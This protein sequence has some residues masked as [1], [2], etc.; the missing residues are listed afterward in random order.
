MKTFVYKDLKFDGCSRWLM[1]ILL[2]CISLSGY[3]QAPVITSFS[4]ASAKPGDAVTLTGTDFNTT[5]TNNIVFFGATRGTVT[6]ATA[7]SVTVTVPTGATYAPITLLNS[8]TAL[9]CASRSPFHPVYTPA[10][11]GISSNDISSKVDFSTAAQPQQVNIGDMDGDGKPDLVFVNLNS[12]SV[13]VLRNTSSSGSMS[14]SASSFTTGVGPYDVAIGDLD[15]DGKLDLAVVNSSSQS[16]T[17]SMFRNTSSSGL[18]SFAAPINYGTGTVPTHLAIG[19]LDVDGKPDVAVLNIGSGTISVFRNQSTIGSFSMGAGPT[20]SV[21][22]GAWGI[23]IGDLDNDGKPELVT[24][25]NNS[26]LFSV[27]RNTSSK[28]YREFRRKG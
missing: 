6:A 13:T 3:A 9:A 1:T 20:L 14:F 27:L 18:V 21:G 23:E 24:V 26:N 17:V 7:T 2:I 15:G 11:A 19:D 4:P 5:T 25:N 8:G 16:Y 12:E 10:K 22:T 28:P